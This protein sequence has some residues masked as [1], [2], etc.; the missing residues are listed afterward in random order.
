MERQG[1]RWKELA[2][3][4]IEHSSIK[5]KGEMRTLGIMASGAKSSLR[6]R[7]GLSP[8]QWALGRGPK[9]PVDLVGDAA[10]CGARGLAANDEA[11][12]TTETA[13]KLDEIKK[14]R[15]AVWKR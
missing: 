10:N 1:A 9:M 14:S 13:G 3:R 4:A 12:R 15:Y 6:R 5:G 2:A 11:I 7:G 8:A